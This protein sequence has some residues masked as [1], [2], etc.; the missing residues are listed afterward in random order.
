VIIK[1][2]PGTKNGHAA[3][4]FASSP[5]H[6]SWVGITRRTDHP[7]RFA[8]IFQ[9]ISAMF[10]TFRRSGRSAGS[11]LPLTRRFLMR[12]I[13]G[14]AIAAPFATMGHAA[15]AQRMD[16]FTYITTMEATTDVGQ[17]VGQPASAIEPV[18]TAE[19]EW[20]AY[21]QLPIKEGQDFHYTCE[22]DS[23]WI[24]LKAY[25]FDLTLDDQLG[26]VGHDLSVEPWWEEA[27]GRITVY[28]GDIAEMYSGNY[29]EN[30]LARARTTAVRKVFD[31]VGLVS[32]DAQDR[33]S[34]EQALLAGHPVYFKSTV[35]FLDWDQATWVCPDGDTYPVVL[36]N[37]HA[38]I[39][40]GFNDHDVIIRDPLGPTTTNEIRPWQYRVSWD[41]YLA[42]IAAQGND[43]VA[44]S[45]APDRSDGTG[46][47]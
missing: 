17:R 26:V 24:V 29:R 8:V 10:H 36:T 4:T 21:I 37:D 47:G 5:Y 44:V 15:I 11:G 18:V 34:T 35:D 43:A 38:L 41:R 45:P 13:A 27:P 9:E 7:I 20:H 46:G 19:G 40:M 16:P 33:T 2:C 28:G 12:A 6:G 1:Q 31:H 30:L 32:T 25:G 14:G 39:V 22:F 3:V 42:V 23:S